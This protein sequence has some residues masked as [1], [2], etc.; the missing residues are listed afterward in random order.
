LRSFNPGRAQRAKTTGKNRNKNIGEL[1][2]ISQESNS[3]SGEPWRCCQA[4]GRAA[5]RAARRRRMPK[6]ALHNKVAFA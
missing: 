4:P 2:S 1:N 6:S 5:H 3:H